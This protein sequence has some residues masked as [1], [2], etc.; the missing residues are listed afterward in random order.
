MARIFCR[1]S[2]AIC[3]LLIFLLSSAALEAQTVAVAEV[4][5]LITDQTVA[6]VVNAQVIMTETDKDQSHTVV[7]DSRGQYVLPNLPV[8]PYRLEAVRTAGRRNIRRRKHDPERLELRPADRRLR[9]PHL[10][11]R[12]EAYL[13]SGGNALLLSLNKRAALQIGKRLS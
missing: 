3:V 7:T 8:G 11:I 2:G 1:L 13:L 9:S 4:S 12:H 10:T 6:E 5:G